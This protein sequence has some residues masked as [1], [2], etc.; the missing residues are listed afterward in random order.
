M[1]ESYP[2]GFWGR[3]GWTSNP[4]QLLS[5][6]VLLALSINETANAEQLAV[7]LQTEPNAIGERFLALEASGEAECFERGSGDHFPEGARITGH[8]RQ[9][10]AGWESHGTP[11]ALERACSAAILC[12]L[13]ARDGERV[14]STDDFVADVRSYFYGRPFAERVR[15]D[16]IRE[17]L[18][19]ELIS[20]SHTWTGAVLR[21]G[22][23]TRGQGV[24]AG[25]EGDL[26]KW[27]ASA[28]VGGDITIKNSTGINVVSRS[29]GTGQAGAISSGV[30]EEVYNLAAALREWIPELGLEPVEQARA[31]GLVG[32]LKEAA[33]AGDPGRLRELLIAVRA[34]GV[35]ATG[36]TLGVGLLTL[37]D[38]VATH[39]HV[40]AYRSSSYCDGGI[41]GSTPATS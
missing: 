15:I 4:V 36:S 32:Q 13:D 34:I 40:G 22:I 33:D 19:H 26:V 18:K 2:A 21:P 23:T 37:V 25:F 39:I 35:D 6:R 3:N 24:V 9:V 12:W 41:G 29:P 1:K 8:G 14:M 10:V 11:R 17:L 20:G 5:Q 38:L 28:S 27:Q 7:E 16:A 31:L 30:R